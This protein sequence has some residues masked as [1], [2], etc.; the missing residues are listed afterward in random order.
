MMI[1]IV[2]I[3]QEIN[4]SVWALS[5][6]SELCP[7]SSPVRENQLQHGESSDQKTSRLPWRGMGEDAVLIGS[8]EDSP[9]KKASKVRS[10]K[11]ELE[12]Y[13][14]TAL[15]ENKKRGSMKNEGM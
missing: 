10:P 11:K 4:N 12:A 13:V 14:Q 6:D 3:E 8:N 1:K 5:L 7:D 2:Y 9:S 15:Q